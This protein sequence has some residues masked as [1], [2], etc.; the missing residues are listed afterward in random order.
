[1]FKVF[2]ISFGLYL[3]IFGWY[4]VINANKIA[5]MC[6]LFHGSSSDGRAVVLSSSS[7][8]TT[9][10]GDVITNEKSNDDNSSQHSTKTNS[11]APRQN[12]GDTKT[13]QTG[14][15]GLA[16]SKRA[17]RNTTDNTATDSSSV[18]SA[19]GRQKDGTATNDVKAVE[20][21]ATKAGAA[22]SEIEDIREMLSGFQEENHAL[23][24]TLSTLNS[25]MNDIRAANN[26]EMNMIKRENEKLL[27]ENEAHLL[28]ISVLES[29]LR[30][31]DINGSDHNN[32][33][34]DDKTVDDVNHNARVGVITATKELD[35]TSIMSPAKKYATSMMSPAKKDA[36]SMMSPAKKESYILRNSEA[37]I[38]ERDVKIKQEDQR[39]VE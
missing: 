19:N 30:K 39:T 21:G 6:L 23:K 5:I 24:V 34:K 7:I 33:D 37:Q 29:M 17:P 11:S 22:Y 28:K 2:I 1:M 16:L 26:N 36:T 14:F 18:G 10:L 35:A 32:Y 31:G 15:L 12:Q 13:A 3:M 9:A 25:E 38:T 4:L 27:E 20:N 8:N